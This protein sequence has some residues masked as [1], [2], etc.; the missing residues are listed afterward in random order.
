MLIDALNEQAQKIRELKNTNK[1]LIKDVTH[2]SNMY[3]QLWKKLERLIKGQ[4][5]NPTL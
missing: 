2:M 3:D 1:S 4:N 5:P